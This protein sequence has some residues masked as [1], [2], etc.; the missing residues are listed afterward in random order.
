MSGEADVVVARDAMFTCSDAT[1]QEIAADIA[2]QH[3]DGMVVASCSPKLHTFTFRGVAQRAG[4]NPYRY[5]QVNLRE[6][7]S[8]THTDDP[9]GATRKAIR[10]VRAG[11]ARTR[12][13]EPLEPT[14]VR[15]VPRALVI[16]GGVAGMRAAIGLA[17]IGLG[18]LLVER[19][20]ALGGLGAPAWARTYP[21]GAHG[22]RPDRPPGC[23][24]RG[25]ITE[26]TVLT[27]A[28]LVAQV[29]DLR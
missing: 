15:T 29:G 9:E 26:I 14:V 19:E 11:I 20:P 18:V 6:Q 23:G 27:G 13:A 22:P 3:L 28:E 5:T 25:A 7:C 2:E 21:H 8:W 24:D 12:L 4:L 1:Q 17:E 10:L 16:G